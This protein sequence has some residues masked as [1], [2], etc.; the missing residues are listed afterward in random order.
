M[1]SKQENGDQIYDESIILT[2][3]KEYF[4]LNKTLSYDML[5]DFLDFID[6]ALQSEED[7]EILWNEFTQNS[8]DIKE[9][10]YPSCEKVM[11][12]FSKSTK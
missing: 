6:L 11:I 2:R 12:E 4:H 10:D 1:T 5:D 8:C 3:V 9:I 7:K